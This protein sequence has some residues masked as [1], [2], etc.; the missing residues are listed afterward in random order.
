MD[1]P[2]DYKNAGLMLIISGGFNALSSLLMVM[3]LIW[4]CIGVLWL[5]PL[6][7][8]V[9]QVVIGIAM[10]GGERKPECKNAAIM[11]IVA[12]AIN[13]NPLPMILA[14]LA[15]SNVAKPEIVGWLEQR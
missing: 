6:A 13:L 11:G 10:Q 12:G 8:G 5:I 3:M 7:M 15:M 1:A 2:N 4:F 9:Y 14:F